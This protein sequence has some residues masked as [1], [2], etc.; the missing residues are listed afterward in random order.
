MQKEELLALAFTWTV[1][2]KEGLITKADDNPNQPQFVRNIKQT[3]HHATTRIWFEFFSNFHKNLVQEILST[4]SFFIRIV[5]T[6]KEESFLPVEADTFGINRTV[7]H[8][9]S[10]GY[11]MEMS[12]AQKNTGKMPN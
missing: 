9:Q 4:V 1:F 11:P 12:P 3:Q 8:M 5:H 2:K 10:I 7:K 6:C